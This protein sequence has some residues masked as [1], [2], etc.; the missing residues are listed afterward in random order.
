MDDLKD[1]AKDLMKS[2]KNPF[3]TGPQK[4]QGQGRRLG[5][6]AFPSSSSE[7][8][9]PTNSLPGPS[10]RTKGLPGGVS[11]GGGPA[12]AG[13]SASGPQRIFQPQQQSPSSLPAGTATQSG[14]GAAV[15]GT[16]QRDGGEQ[17]GAVRH[18]GPEPPIRG[19]AGSC[20]SSS[21]GSGSCGQQSRREQEARPPN[22]HI[23]G[24]VAEAWSIGGR[25]A[26]LANSAE[27]ASSAP[28]L[29][30]FRCP[31]C[32]QSFPSEAHV[33]QHVDSCLAN[34]LGS[35][36]SDGTGRAAD[37]SGAPPIIGPG[38]DARWQD[39]H[40]EVAAFLSAGPPPA[41]VEVLARLLRNVATNPQEEKFRRVRLRDRKSVV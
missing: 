30:S 14:G 31:V 21:G 29:R 32:E 41:T 17:T 10:Q 5:G 39:L 11:T 8:S 1:K 26:E 34:S 4:F 6:G 28:S 13:D 22:S 16:Q 24:E 7:P 38:A 12:Y 19:P 36:L 27:V 9:A 18:P 33:S 23:T 25:P 15:G 20:S 40:D 2:F 3:R 37:G 35:S